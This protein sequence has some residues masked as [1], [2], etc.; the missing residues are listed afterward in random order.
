[1]ANQTRYLSRSQAEYSRNGS[2]MAFTFAQ[3]RGN[4]R[5]GPGYTLK[6]I[7][8][9][10]SL[11]SLVH[12]YRLSLSRVCVAFHSF[13]YHHVKKQNV[14]WNGQSATL[15]RW[16]HDFNSFLYPV[17]TRGI[18]LNRFK[19]RAY[20]CFLMHRYTIGSCETFPQQRFPVRLS[21]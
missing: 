10:F 15:V 7:D 12:L 5:L 6:P 21:A 9:G 11:W 17:D 3:I 13:W 19:F 2:P 18:Y 4:N 1:M 8:T 14:L 20:I 16:K